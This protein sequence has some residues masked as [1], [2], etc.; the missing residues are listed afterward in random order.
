MPTPIANDDFTTDPIDLLLEVYSANW[1]NRGV[2]DFTVSESLDAV[3]PDSP[4]AES[5]AF[6]NADTFDDDQY[7]TF[8]IVLANDGFGAIGLAVRS[9]RTLEECYGFYGDSEGS[10]SDACYLYYLESDGSWVELGTTGTLSF[11]VGHVIRLE[12]E[13]TTLTPTIDGS[14]TGTPGA[15]TDS[16]YSS[17]KPGLTGWRGDAAVQYADDWEAGNLADAER[18][19]FITKI[20]RRVPAPRSRL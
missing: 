7:A 13:G 15:Q 11:A 18:T 19:P 10:S 5:I 4:D 3:Q 16:L 20:I 9:G 2:D 12:A 14:T 1:T 8:D 17:G 6:W